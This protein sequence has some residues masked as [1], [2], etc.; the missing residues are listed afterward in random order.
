MMRLV[1]E[2]LSRRV[3]GLHQAAYILGGFAILS[4]LLAFV[5]D[6][7]L[8]FT[9]GAGVELDIYFAAFR[10]PDLIFVGIASLVSAYVLIPALASKDKFSQ[11][12]YID[13]VVVGY[14]AIIGVTSIIA[15]IFA[16][17]ILE[18]LFP[19]LVNLGYLDQLISMTRIMLLQPI[20]LGFS[21]IF[22][23]ILQVK[24]RYILYATTPLVY[25]IGIILGVVVFYPIFGLAGLAWGVVLGSI[26]HVGIQIPSIASDG[27][28]IKFPSSYN[29]SAFLDTI[30]V[31]LPR[32]ITLA[33]SQ[34]NILVL[35]SMA[36]SLAVG[37]IAIFTF[38]FNLQAV[39]LAIIG[40]SYSVAAFPTLAKM[41][42]RG[43]REQ[44]INQ[45]TISA[46]HIIFWSLPAIALAIVL[47]AHVVRVIL[48][49]G[50]FDWTD[51]RLT[52]A[53][54]AL[55]IISLTAHALMLLLI[56]AY[57]AAGKTL[58]PFIVSFIVFALSILLGFIF[59]GFFGNEQIKLFIESLLRVEEV[60]GSDVLMLPLAYSISSIVG[61]ILLVV[62]FEIRYG[63]FINKVK[64]AFIESIAAAGIAGV[65]SYLVL[66]IL[67]GINEATTLIAVLGY[68]LAA[69]LS[70]IFAA[71]ILFWISGNREFYE[72]TRTA[73]EKYRARAIQSGEIEL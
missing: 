15:F 22:A 34:A 49:T 71:I 14:S 58:T 13:T 20:F 56:R 66:T 57:Y 1:F 17:F 23:A 62:L 27:F 55:F 8:A 46:R 36:G 47:R 21:N 26:L 7:L 63:G 30:S 72:I 32:A 51:T 9:F 52:A 69:G 3:L 42:S 39:P 40:A 6:R 37:S 24:G 68:G 16:P 61:A 67:G 11:H 29:F 43:D 59:L 35:I 73:H 54:F 2:F 25:N 64:R 18:K 60:P 50:E 41:L 12:K 4:S 44:Y 45:V 65:I 53:A 33:L 10:I 19:S 48:G 38:S 31:S 70:G 28:L 5:R